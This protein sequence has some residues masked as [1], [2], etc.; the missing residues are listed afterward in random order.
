MSEGLATTFR[1]LRETQNEAATR[2]LIPALDSRFPSV[3]DAALEALLSRRSPAGHREVVGRLHTFDE[4]WRLAVGKNHSRMLPALRDAVISS[5]RQMCVNGC[6]AAV[7]FSQ[8]DLIPAL[9]IA[10][11]DPANPNAAVASEALLDLAELLGGELAEVRDY[12][13][14]RDVQVVRRRAVGALEM[15]VGRFA[16]HR[17][18]EIVEAF[19]LLTY[20]DNA[21][22]RQILQD[23]YHPAFVVLV[24]ALSKSPQAAAIGLLLSF[25]DDAH[26]PSAALSIVSKRSDRKFVLALLHKVGRDSAPAVTQNLRRLESIAWFGNDLSFLDGWTESEQAAAVRLAMIS[27]MPRPQAFS[28]VERLLVRGKPGGRRAAAEALDKFRGADANLLALQALDDDDPEVQSRILLQ[29]RGRG[30]PGALARLVEMIDSPHD[31][32]RDAARRCL[33]EFSFSRYLSSFDLLDEEVRAST[34]ELVKKVDPQAPAMLRAELT[35]AVRSRRLRG[36][37]MARALGLVAEL[38]DAILPLAKDEDHL[39][40][41][42][43]ALTLGQSTSAAARKALATALGDRSPTVQG[44]AGTSL[45]RQFPGLGA[46][47]A[48]PVTP[49]QTAAPSPPPLAATAAPIQEPSPG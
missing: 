39:I 38:E 10:L 28:V 17:R 11:E 46:A 1:L 21:V 3:R 15:S 22:L 4:P 13:Q 6:R 18:R 47:G 25:V 29:L 45:R 31:P 30:I 44:A 49:A 23:P 19:V 9:L 43:A 12:N 27:G 34:G 8:Y 26:A 36:L 20:R 7:W 33:A 16:R 41:A 14:R 35:S 48:A 2:V 42:E 32:V 24:D 5:D 37:G 40:R